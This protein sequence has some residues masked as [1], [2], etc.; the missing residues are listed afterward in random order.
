MA[1]TTMGGGSRCANGIAGACRV[2]AVL[3]TPVIPSTVGIPPNADALLP[4]KIAKR[5]ILATRCSR[6]HVEAAV[7]GECQAGCRTIVAMNGPRRHRNRSCQP[8][9]GPDSSTS[10]R[11]TAGMATRYGT[12]TV[13]GAV[14]ALAPHAFVAVTLNV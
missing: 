2:Q 5:D 8:L 14:E 4:S 11:A 9:G 1:R 3:R 13:W 12:T 10:R 7:S 6:H